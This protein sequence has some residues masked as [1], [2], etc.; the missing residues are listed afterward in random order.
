MLL[1]GDVHTADRKQLDAVCAASDPPCSV[2]LSTS[3]TTLVVMESGETSEEETS[4][5]GQRRHATT[6]GRGTMSSLL[7]HAADLVESSAVDVELLADSLR[8]RG[9]VGDGTAT[10]V[11][12]CVS[13]R[14]ACELLGEVVAS[15]AE[16]T[17]LC[18]ALRAHG[19]DDEADCLA[20]VQSL[21][22][23]T[24]SSQLQPSDFSSSPSATVNDL[25]PE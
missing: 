3:L 25:L 17:A 5:S 23:F 19:C 8:R 11:R 13:R 15:K 10:A 6:G 16:L 21:L 18:D 4:K 12:R 22:H 14:A 7:R 20:A 24:D 1:G 9:V 2:T